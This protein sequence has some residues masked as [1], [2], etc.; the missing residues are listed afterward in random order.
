MWLE[1][2]LESRALAGLMQILPP[3]LESVWEPQDKVHLACLMS[4]I[5]T[6]DRKGAPNGC[7]VL[8]ECW[9]PI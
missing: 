8:A 3:W 5:D 4:V 6:E 2:T 9:G 1:V 7:R